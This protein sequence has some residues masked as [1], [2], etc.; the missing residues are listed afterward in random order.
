MALKRINT[1]LREEEETEQVS[2]IKRAWVPVDP[3]AT[4][5][6]LAIENGTFKWNEVPEEETKTKEREKRMGLPKTV[7]LVLAG[8]Q[9]MPPV[10]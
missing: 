10:R 7:G 5:D 1:Y 9:V 4:N 3:L 8:V 2:S 6:G